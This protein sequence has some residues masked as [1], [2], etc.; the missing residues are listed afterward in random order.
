MKK[1]HLSYAVLMLYLLSIGIFYI[2]NIV[3]LSLIYPNLE[4]IILLIA[5]G[6]KIYI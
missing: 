6:I 1:R 3:S 4:I 2:M 5:I